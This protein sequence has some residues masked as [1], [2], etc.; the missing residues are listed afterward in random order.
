MQYRHK[1]HKENQKDFGFDAVKNCETEDEYA[2]LQAF[3]SL[4]CI[5]HCSIA[6]EDQTTEEIH[7]D[8]LL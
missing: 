1:F 8:I 2:E 5:E 6:V 4:N 7:L 3:Q